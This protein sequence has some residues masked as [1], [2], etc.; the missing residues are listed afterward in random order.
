MKSEYLLN[1][2]LSKSEFIENILSGIDLRFINNLM[3]REDSFIYKFLHRVMPKKYRE[4]INI[5]IKD[6]KISHNYKKL[7][8]VEKMGTSATF[9][10]IN[11]ICK[12]IKKGSYLNIGIWKGFSLFCGMLDTECEVIGVDNFGEFNGV[13]AKKDFGK[14]FNE[15]K[16]DNHHFYESDALDFLKNCTKKFDFYFYDALHT[17]EYQYKALELADK[18]L[19]KG[20]LILIDDICWNYSDE[21]LKATQDFLK[22]YKNKYQLLLDI[23]TKY[24]RHPSFWNGYFLIEKISQ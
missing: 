4:N 18:N 14:K 24:N 15:I 21:P 3:N 20:A 17:Y 8:D 7:R 19:N 12:S 2:N 13:N 10:L 11:S 16:K 22:D 23:R 6:K 9:Y 5:N 1:K